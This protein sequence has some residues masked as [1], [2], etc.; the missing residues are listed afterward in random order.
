MSTD[1]SVVLTKRV[2][3][4]S[5]NPVTK[6]DFVKKVGEIAK[7]II[8]FL[9]KNGCT[10][11]GHI[12]FIS[13]TDGE[14]YLQLSVLDMAQKPKIQGILKKTFDKIKLTFNIIEFGVCKEEIDSKINKEIENIQAYFNN[15]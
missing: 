9:K 14:D 8:D 6:E 5:S 13:T 12:K 4:T 15:K 3:I 2:I 11:L 1:S 7:N 10:K